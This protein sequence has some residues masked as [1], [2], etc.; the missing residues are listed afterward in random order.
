MSA[1]IDKGGT[2]TLS[3]AGFVISLINHYAEKKDWPRVLKLYERLSRLDSKNAKVWANL[4]N[5]YAKFGDKKKA[6]KAARKT[7]ELDP[8]MKKSADDF[9]QRL[10]G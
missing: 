3:P 6:V 5:L 9:I 7:G 4:A 10:G 2:S 1:C 8:N